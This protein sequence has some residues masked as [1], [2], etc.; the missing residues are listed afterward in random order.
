MK[1]MLLARETEFLAYHIR[2]SS[3]LEFNFHGQAVLFADSIQSEDDKLYQY[4]VRNHARRHHI[5]ISVVPLDTADYDTPFLCKRGNLIRFN[6]RTYWIL[7]RDQWT[8]PKFSDDTFA[9]DCL[10]LRQNPRLQPE[11]V[12]AKI[13]LQE[14]LADG[15]NNPYYIERWRIF[16]MEN[17]IPFTFTGDRKF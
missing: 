1:K 2:K 13:P 8:V 6:D 9:V 7:T 5:R 14:V 11:E 16:C 10:L 17:G 15:S 3:A 12:L 4:N